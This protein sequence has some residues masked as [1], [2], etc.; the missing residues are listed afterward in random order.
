MR[1]SGFSFARNAQKLYYPVAEA[2][3]SILPVCDEFFVAVGA[4]DEDDRTREEIEAIGDSRVHIIDT[5]WSD[6]ERLKGKVHGQ[7]TNVA[8]EKCT[9]DWCFYI[10]ADE[11][12][13]EDFLPRIVKRCGELLDD[14]EV[15]GLL[16]RYKHFWGDYTH[17]VVNHAWYPREIRIV[18]NGLGIRSWSSAQS[19]R[20]DGR[21]LRVAPVDAEVFHYGWVRPPRLMNKKR[22]EFSTTHAGR[23]AA[24][25]LY[26]REPEEFDYGSLEKARVYTGS[27]PAVMKDRAARMDWGDKLQYSGRS[28]VRHKHDRLKYRLLTFVEQRLLGGKTHL[29]SKNYRLAAGKRG[30]RKRGMVRGIF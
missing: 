10:Q 9:G 7:Q 20:R 24:E 4:G 29:A 13:H 16:F 28:P 27:I 25:A 17:Y 2:V 22:R 6:R 18:R 3:R 1:I 21:K 12:V 30:A 14:R 11:V 8:L 19:F 5:V 26:A 23:D 15:E